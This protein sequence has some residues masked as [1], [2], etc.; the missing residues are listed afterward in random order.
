MH[1]TFRVPVPDPERLADELMVAQDEIRKLKALVA[2]QDRLIAAQAL[3]LDCAVDKTRAARAAKALLTSA[4][5]FE[6]FW[7][8][9][10]RKAA[11]Q[12]ARKAWDKAVAK[13]EPKVIIEAVRAFAASKAAENM[14][15]VPYPGTWLNA[16]RWLDDR[17][18]W[19]VQRGD[20][21]VADKRA[22]RDAAT[23]W[24]K[25]GKENGQ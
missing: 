20:K 13:T 4:Q 9:Y 10:P 24:S 6:V 19:N 1:E 25:W 21:T 8:Q 18:E 11:K 7:D 23:D 14:Q 16:A 17:S 3:A 12:S 22:D 15:F 2:E 5:L